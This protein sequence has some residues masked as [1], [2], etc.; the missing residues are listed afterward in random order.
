MTKEEYFALAEKELAGILELIKRKGNDYSGGSE[1]VLEN[2]K[3]AEKL[4]LA[5]A[6]VGLLLRMMDK[7]QRVKSFVT[8]G[9]L[10][11]ENESAADAARDIIGYA[12]AL[13]G[14]M[15]EPKVSMQAMKME[16]AAK[17]AQF[18]LLNSHIWRG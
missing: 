16:L 8:K 10:K 2:F 13:I 15:H 4:G 6:E 3:L 5:K 18:D 9:E 12:L 17:D 7:I 1:D 14:L 11:V